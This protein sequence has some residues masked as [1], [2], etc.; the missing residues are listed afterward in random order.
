MT[1]IAN[2]SL[3]TLL[4]VALACGDGGKTSDGDTSSSTTAG[5]GS[6][7]VVTTGQVT[8]GGGSTSGGGSGSGDASTGTPGSSTGAPGTT[9]PETTT[10]P[11]TTTGMTTNMTGM[12]GMTDGTDGSSG[13]GSSSGGDVCSGQGES[14]AAPGQLC[15]RGLDCCAGVPVPMGQE[16]CSNNCP[17]SD[18]NAK[19]EFAAI[20]AA[21]VLRRVVALP[22]TSWRYRKDGPEVR[23]VGPMAQDF[24]AAFGLWNSD[25][26][27]FPLDA[28]GVSMAAIQALHARVVAAEAENEELRARLDRLERRLDPTP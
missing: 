3:L 18:R 13:S 4:V 23:H 20:D 11:G 1:R 5:T 21:D 8:T 2:L 12:T 17:I 24:H 6:T 7:G 9:G 10:T 26:M 25:T 14:C 27:I 28:S 16:F 19:T 15:C 22:I